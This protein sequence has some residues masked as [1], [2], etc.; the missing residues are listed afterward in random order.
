MGP[1][2]MAEVADAVRSLSDHPAS[3]LKYSL[4][5]ILQD[6]QD[7]LQKFLEFLPKRFRN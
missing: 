3:D 4:T 5:E 7:L 6:Q 2:K 1:A